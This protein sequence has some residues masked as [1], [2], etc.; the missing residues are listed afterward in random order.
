[1]EQQPQQQAV[2]RDELCPPNK[3]YDLI[4][5]FWHTLKLDDSKDK[6]KFFLDTKEFKFSI[7]DFVNELG[8]S[9]PIRLP[10][11]FVTKKI[12]ATVADIGKIFARFLNTRV[13]GHDQPPFQIM[14]VIYC[15]IKNIHV[16]SVE[17]LWE[18]LH[19]SLMHP[20]KLIPYPR[21][22]KIIIDHFMTENP[23]IPRRLHE[24]YHRVAIDEIVKSIFNSGKNKEGKRMRIP[25]WMLTEEMELTRHYQLYASVFGVDVP[26]TQ[27]QPIES[28]Q[29]T[30]MTFSAN[31]TPNPAT[32]H[33][34]SSAPR[35]PTVVRFRIRSQQI[36]KLRY[37]H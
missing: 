36:L 12:T 27:S 14:Q 19:Y 26:T 1:M 28:T 37:Q 30:H 3:Q 18:G 17:L 22:T 2:S 15:F 7:D 24:H 34:E 10:T 31:K 32:T 33:G 21:F 23:D 4:D 9:L 6:F 25:D 13:T 29:G 16:D 5:Q 11:H 8:F 35:K 20:T